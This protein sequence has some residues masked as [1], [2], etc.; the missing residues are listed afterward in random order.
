MKNSHPEKMR[1]DK[2][3][4]LERY[5]ERLWEKSNL[6]GDIEKE[7]LIHTGIQIVKEVEATHH[8]QVTEEDD[9]ESLFELL[10]KF[11]RANFL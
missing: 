6:E 8:L 9:W 4:I 10:K 2:L 1:S 5:L 3:E 7:E 11:K